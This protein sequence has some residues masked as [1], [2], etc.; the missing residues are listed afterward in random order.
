M[1]PIGSSFR[2]LKMF[3]QKLQLKP[4]KVWPTN[5]QVKSNPSVVQ[6][7]VLCVLMIVICPGFALRVSL[8]DCGN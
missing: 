2:P 7:G 6:K 8:Y 5:E 4:Y 1:T 3:E